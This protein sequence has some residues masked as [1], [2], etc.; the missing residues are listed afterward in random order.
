MKLIPPNSDTAARRRGR[1]RTQPF[2]P[3]RA[4]AAIAALLSGDEQSAI[5][6]GITP[7]AMR[8]YCASR[9]GEHG[10][11]VAAIRS[12]LIATKEAS[13]SFTVRDQARDIVRHLREWEAATLRGKPDYTPQNDPLYP[14]YRFARGDLDAKDIGDVRF[15]RSGDIGSVEAE[16]LIVPPSTPAYLIG[17]VAWTL[18]LVAKA[19]SFDDFGIAYFAFA[20]LGEAIEEKSD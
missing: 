8:E 16:T 1:P 18:S 7:E 2:L 12:G 19:G 20:R 17:N 14:V 5:D 4:R 9:R 15:G 10:A 6:H 3:A 13:T 11:A